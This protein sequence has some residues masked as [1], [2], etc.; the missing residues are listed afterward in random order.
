MAAPA[1]PIELSVPKP[2]GEHQ[3]GVAQLHL[4][5]HF[6]RDPWKADHQRELMVSLWYPTRDAD[7][8]PPAPWFGAGLA[9]ALDEQAA[10]F[11]GI[12][13]GCVDWAGA[14]TDARL[15]APVD[16]STGG[17]PVVLYSPGFGVSRAASTTVVEELASRG[18]AV[19]TIDHTYETA[20][21]FPGG[22]VERPV[23]ID[24][25]DPVRMKAAID[26]RVADTRFVL[27]TLMALDAGFNP[28]AEGHRLPAGL[29]GAL[30]L[31][32]VGMYGHSYGGFTAGETMYWDHRIRAGVDLDGILASSLGGSADHPYLPGEV[33]RHGLPRPFLLMGAETV[34]DPAT[35]ALSQHTHL[36]TMDRS[37]PQFWSS[38]RG[39]KRDLLMVDGRHMSYTDYEVIWHKLADQSVISREQ[40]ETLVGTVDPGRSVTAQRAYLT[41][42]FDLHL[43]HRD[44]GLFSGPSS[45]YPEMAFIV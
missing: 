33:V 22:R 45:R 11:A 30:D 42:F 6:R 24:A 1:V 43:R 21:E 31:A 8:Y 39:W 23:P 19:V 15:G 40:V 41:A 18:Y 32:D 29:R 20:V 28:D 34:T 12:P 38:Q 35:G 3:V 9:V 25:T 14:R 7:R 2:T 26:T 13:K 17:L 37:W 44:S 36:S 5:D 4:V 16:A 10:T 27:D